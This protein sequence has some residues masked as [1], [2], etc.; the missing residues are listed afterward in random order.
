MKK[1]AILILLLFVFAGC[2]CA[3][4]EL[5]EAVVS[6][7]SEAYPAHEVLCKDNWGTTSAA[8]LKCGDKQILCIAE[9]F[10]GDW[11]LTVQSETALLQDQTV[12][13]F[14][15]DTNYTL[16]W[17]Y[18]SDNLHRAYSAHKR[19]GFWYCYGM[20]A[21][22]TFSNENVHETHLAWETGRLYYAT[23]LCDEN[24]NILSSSH[25]EPAPAPWL[26]EQTNLTVFDASLFSMPLDYYHSWLSQ[27][28]TIAAAQELFPGYACL[29]GCAKQEHLEFLLEKPDGSRYYAATRW[30]EQRGWRSVL[31]SPLPQGTSYGL[32]NFTSSLVIGDLLVNVSAVDDDTFGVSYIYAH[33][34]SEEMFQLGKNW[35][36]REVPTWQ[37][38]QYGDH[39][40]SDVT[41]IDWLSLPGTYE[42][43]LEGLNRS[44]WATV[45][46]PN[47]ADRLHLRVQPDRGA[48]SQGKYYNGTPVRVLGQKDG[49]TNVSIFGVE[50]WM[51][52]KYLAFGDDMEQVRRVTPYRVPKEDRKNHY[53]YTSPNAKEIVANIQS[54]H[55]EALVLGL[56][57]DEW[58]HVWLVN[59][60]IGG[61]VPVNEWFEGNG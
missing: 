16:F 11:R 18:A 23:Y 24:D 50:G 14:M 38:A 10:N 37:D 61:Y 35:I 15:L 49:W 8:V 20:I 9:N 26:R 30:D 17:G 43:A 7:F 52:S 2:A 48:R 25:Y 31:S 41:M 33:N 56:V 27:E 19:E 47:P 44:R 54:L 58:Y 12:T 4:E 42:E 36:S 22:E 5:P 28:A 45:N 29:G 40:W 51:L 39:P 55:S 60:D 53:V 13:Q 3:E 6:L 59:E 1:L 46:N 57:G 32:E 34:G 21:T